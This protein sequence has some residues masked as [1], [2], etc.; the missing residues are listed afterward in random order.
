MGEFK[1]HDLFAHVKIFERGQ[2]AGIR[3]PVGL[4]AFTCRDRRMRQKP[5]KI[6]AR[7]GRIAHE[8]TPDVYRRKPR[9]IPC[10]FGLG[11]PLA[12][13]VPQR[14]GDSGHQTEPVQSLFIHVGRTKFQVGV[15]SADLGVERVLRSVQAHKRRHYL[16]M[17][18]EFERIVLRIR[19]R[20]LFVFVKR[21]MYLRS[22]AK[23]RQ[24]Q[25]RDLR[26]C[27][28]L[29]VLHDIVAQ[30]MHS[31]AHTCEFGGGDLAGL[32]K[33]LDVRP[34]AFRPSV[35]APLAKHL[36]ASAKG[37]QAYRQFPR[38]RRH[39][40]LRRPYVR[41]IGR[42]I[43]LRRLFVK[44][45]RP[46]KRDRERKRSAAE[47][48]MSARIDDAHHIE[49]KFGILPPASLPCHP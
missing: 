17:L 2:F 30:R 14:K 3:Q 45:K 28:L 20:H 23:S 34:R 27:G 21:D 42:G 5:D 44:R 40:R 9:V 10:A 25:E 13:P 32:M 16:G 39:I 41:G 47:E 18:H 36:T 43:C 1:P 37:I 38:L 6:R 49:V 12:V 46:R 22:G 29:L 4:F 33:P 8:R 35:G 15:L 24:P 7:L 26:G 31:A 48:R 11:N 19:H